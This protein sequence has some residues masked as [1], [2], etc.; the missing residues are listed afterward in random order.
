MRDNISTPKA[1]RPTC[2]I[3]SLALPLG[4][5]ILEYILSR[6][7][8]EGDS[9]ALSLYV[10]GEYALLAAIIAG[11]IL[12]IVALVRGEKWK[13]LSYMALVLNLISAALLLKDLI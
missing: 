6:F 1:L 13:V 2:G 10:L 4:L 9:G 5:A 8:P 3:A 12:A 7:V 11:A